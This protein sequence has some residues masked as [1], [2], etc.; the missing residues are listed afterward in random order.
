MSRIGAG[1]R[2]PWRVETRLIERPC[3]GAGEAE[4][5]RRKGLGSGMVDDGREMWAGAEDLR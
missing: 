1:L 5:S 4:M 2:E 3:P